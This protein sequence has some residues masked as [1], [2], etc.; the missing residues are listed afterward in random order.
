MCRVKPDRMVA[1][2][3]RN[4][5]ELPPGSPDPQSDLLLYRPPTDIPGSGSLRDEE[6]EIFVHVV[7]GDTGIYYI[8]YPSEPK[9]EVS[10]I[11]FESRLEAAAFILGKED[12]ELERLT[13]PDRHRI[14][15]HFP[16]YFQDR[17]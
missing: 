2:G 14:R 15:S 5:K 16:E 12:G 6:I 13:E 7:P 10:I 9:G 17:V 4:S 3:D 1:D 11:P 8:Y